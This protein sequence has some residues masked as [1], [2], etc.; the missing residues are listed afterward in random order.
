MVEV[1][2]T[3]TVVDITDE[4]DELD[5][6]P[7]DESIQTGYWSRKVIPFD[8]KLCKARGVARRDSNAIEDAYS[9]GSIGI[10]G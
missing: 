2:S 1:S 6:S 9:N 5:D 8:M 3:P 4:A 10:F 7:C